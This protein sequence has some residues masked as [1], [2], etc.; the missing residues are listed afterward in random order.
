VLRARLLVALFGV[1]LG[2]AV[3]ILGGWVFFAAMVL[4]TLLGLHEYYRMV[5]PYRPNL[6]VGYL[7]ALFLLA[8]TQWA[9][10]AAI[11]GGVMALLAL[12]FL[13]GMGG[14]LGHHL[15]GRM[16]VTSLGVLWVGLGFAHL[17]LLRSLAHG[18]ALAVLVVGIA[19]VGDTFAFFVGRALGRRRMA[20]RIS[21]KK[22]VEGAIGGLVGAIL[23]ALGVKLYS[24]WLPVEA[25]LIL[26]LVGGLAGQWGDLFES[27]IKRD[28][29]VKDSGRL[30]PG[31]GGVL[32]R[33]DSLLF[34]GAAVYWA[35]LILLP[36]VLGGVPG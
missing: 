18:L 33:F 10:V 31:H 34:A 15:V 3:V 16:A 9:G 35:A 27:A 36:D 14:Q 23:F 1:P 12:L 28:L 17:L 5:R 13:W 26:G 11:A 4:L 30:L 24:D 7:A 8:V 2:V 20:P 22:T 25:A 6:L 19:W 29:Q 32:D 21:P